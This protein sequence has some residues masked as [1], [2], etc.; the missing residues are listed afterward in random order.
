[1]K[2]SVCVEIR[3]SFKGE[4]F[5]PSARIDLDQYLQKGQPVPDFFQL[6]ARV[7]HIDPYSYQYEVMEVGQYVFSAASG[8]AVDFCQPQHFDVAGFTAA[9]QKQQELK[10]V[11]EIARKQ[12][13]IDDLSQHEDIRRALLQAYRQGKAG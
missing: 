2:N 12:L 3:F 1:M 11:A 7:N 8:L 5:A 4:S 10:I 6:V 9:W 13:Q